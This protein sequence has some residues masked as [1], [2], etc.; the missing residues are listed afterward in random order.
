MNKL[1]ALAVFALLSVL[2]TVAPALAD[3]DV[4]SA[5]GTA[6]AELI[7]PITLVNVSDM[8]FGKMIKNFTAGS[9]TVILTPEN[10]VGSVVSS[11]NTELM[12]MGGHG[13]ADFSLSGE[14]G[15]TVLIDAGGT[16]TISKDGVAAPTAQQQMTVSD[17]T[18]FINDGTSDVLL[19][20][21]DT[22]IIPATGVSPGP[23]FGGTLTVNGDTETGSYSGTFTVTASYQ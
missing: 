8:D 4:A 20:D 14:A 12:L 5:T 3:G 23:D 21:G 2:L 10:G 7:A 15:E 6:R 19:N 1:R 22:F 13:D 18:F 9:Q 16:F 11:N 17:I